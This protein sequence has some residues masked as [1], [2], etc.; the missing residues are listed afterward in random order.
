VAGG[1]G[2][3]AR[4]R[5]L[6]ER[7]V[8]LCLAENEEAWMKRNGGAGALLRLFGILNGLTK[9]KRMRE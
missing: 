8:V 3:G 2:R 9:S 6:E 4:R 1:T 7:K 5:R